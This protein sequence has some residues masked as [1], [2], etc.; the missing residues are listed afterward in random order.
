MARCQLSARAFLLL[1]FESSNRASHCCLA[2]THR[3]VAQDHRSQV[4][5]QSPQN[6][7]RADHFSLPKPE[8]FLGPW[9]STEVH[10]GEPLVHTQASRSCTLLHGPRNQCSCS[11]SSQCPG[12]RSSQSTCTNEMP[13]KHGKAGI[14]RCPPFFFDR[15]LGAT[16]PGTLPRAVYIT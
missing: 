14:T 9:R 1:R 11:Q 15:V 5:R 3:K 12:R 7:S 16:L 13:R 6:V 10:A 8:S 2:R 4:R